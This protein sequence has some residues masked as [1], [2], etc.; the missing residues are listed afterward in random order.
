MQLGAGGGGQHG[1]F[2][3]VG[4]QTMAAVKCVYRRRILDG[5]LKWL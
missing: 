2:P 4:P 3:R 5:Y 1:R